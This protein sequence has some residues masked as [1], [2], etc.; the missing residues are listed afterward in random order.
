LAATKYWRRQYF[1]GDK[2]LARQQKL[3]VDRNYWRQ[4]SSR[5]DKILASTKS[6]RRQKSCVDKI[7]AS[8]K[9]HIDK[10]LALTK[11]WHR[12]RRIPLLFGLAESTAADFSQTLLKI[13]FISQMVLIPPHAVAK[14]GVAS[15][16]PAFIGGLSPALYGLIVPAGHAEN[17]T[18]FGAKK[19]S[20]S[21]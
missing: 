8:T 6:S 21:A 5:V 7:L 19:I 18:N 14:C 1:V 13:S 20:V 9:S 2:I 10:N 16:R 3:C 12:H 15:G 11:C 4:Q 17:V